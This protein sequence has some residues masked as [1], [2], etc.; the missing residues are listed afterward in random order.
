MKFRFGSDADFGPHVFVRRRVYLYSHP[1]EGVFR[2]WVDGEVVFDISPSNPPEYVNYGGPGVITRNGEGDWFTNISDLDGSPF[3]I[4][5]DDIEI[6][7]GGVP[8]DP[9]ACADD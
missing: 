8:P 1:T 3:E 4:W 2:M 7:S 9:S 6:W 5:V